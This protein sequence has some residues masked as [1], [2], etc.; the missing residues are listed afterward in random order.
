M[1]FLFHHLSVNTLVLDSKLV[2]Y[3]FCFWLL[4]LRTEGNIN[5][6]THVP[7]T[8][9]TIIIAGCFSSQIQENVAR[10]LLVFVALKSLSSYRWNTHTHRH[11]LRTHAHTVYARTHAHSLHTHAHSPHTQSALPYLLCG[12]ASRHQNT[13]QQLIL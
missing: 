12:Y 6:H 7:N 9:C 4:N 13:I 11:S 5:I 2:T 8:I 10:R 3:C 1:R